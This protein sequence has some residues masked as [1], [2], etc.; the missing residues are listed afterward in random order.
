MLIGWYVD[1][2]YEMSSI[3][4]LDT[5]QFTWTV[6]SYFLDKMLDISREIV[7]YADESYEMSNL[8]SLTNE[9]K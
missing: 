4:L 9:N 2:S 8:F 3:I 6:R 5:R 7:R 1:D